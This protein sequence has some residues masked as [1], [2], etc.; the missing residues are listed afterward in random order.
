M[1]GIFLQE[2]SPLSDLKQ[3]WEK[4]YHFA[5]SIFENIWQ[6]YFALNTLEQTWEKT[7]VC[8]TDFCKYVASIFCTK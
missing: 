1:L 4:D 7:P 8:T 3:T 2:M 6:V 5:P